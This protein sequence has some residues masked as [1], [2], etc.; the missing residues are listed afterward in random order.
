MLDLIM[1]AVFVGI[2]TAIVFYIV[3]IILEYQTINIPFYTKVFICGF[4][5]HIICQIS[6]I[7]TKY[8]EYGVAC[9]DKNYE[10]THPA[11]S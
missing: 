2:L 6:G 3:D 7:N 9:K 4:L 10:K 8:C 11:S 1:E 5:I